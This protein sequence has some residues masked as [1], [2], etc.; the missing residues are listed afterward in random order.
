PYRVTV[1]VGPWMKQ[2]AVTDD[3]LDRVEA[4]G[5]LEALGEAGFPAMAAALHREPAS[6]RVGVCEALGRLNLKEGTPILIDAARDPAPEVRHQA[7]LGLGHIGDLR[8]APSV[9]AG[10]D[11]PSTS[12]QL[13]AANACRA[14]GLC[15]SPHAIARLTD[16]SI[17]GEIP[18]GL[19][20]RAAL[21]RI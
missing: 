7:L 17:H 8:G 5:R 15:A 16:L 18:P 21:V 2:L 9:E 10:L 4:R 11:D 19:W 12:V 13:A 14:P 1:D 3:E 6:A 20:A